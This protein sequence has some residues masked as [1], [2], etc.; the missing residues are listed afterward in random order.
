MDTKKI[1][2]LFI[3]CPLLVFSQQ[4]A[5]KEADKKV[6]N[7]EYLDAIK[8]YE[9][10]YKNGQATPEVIENLANIYYKNASYV[11]ANKWFAKLYT[12]TPQ[13]KSESH[14]RYAQ[15]LKTVGLQ[16]QSKEQLELFKKLSPDQIRTVL[17]N[18][19]SNV[20][21]LTSNV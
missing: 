17:L 12:I 2:F 15:T 9:R 19:T 1:L 20:Q 11:L 16:E 10:L 3:L 14:Y 4:N 5:I 7:F 13:M 21:R 18:S 6:K 8:I